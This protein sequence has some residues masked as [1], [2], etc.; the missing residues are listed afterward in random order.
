MEPEHSLLKSLST[1]T[2]EALNINAKMLGK[3]SLFVLFFAQQPPVG[4][5]LLIQEV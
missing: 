4:Q 5:G 1:K 3:P 2:R